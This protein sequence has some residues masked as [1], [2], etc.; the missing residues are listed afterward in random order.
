MVLLV[1]QGSPV[2]TS[3]SQDLGLE[4]GQHEA[5]TFLITTVN[6]N[7]LFRELVMQGI[8]NLTEIERDRGDREIGKAYR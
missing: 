2:V 3:L 7:T 4:A 1:S 5:S 8:G 6:E